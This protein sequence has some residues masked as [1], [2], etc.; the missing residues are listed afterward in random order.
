M[1]NQTPL[2][3]LITLCLLLSVIHWLPAQPTTARVPSP[4]RELR[5][6]WV[7]TVLNIDYPREGTP[8]A[9]AIREQY[10]NLIDQFQQLGFNTVIFQVRPAADAFYP[11]Q[12]VPWSRFLT[13]QQGR[14]PSDPQFDPLA[15]MIEETHRRGMEFHAWLNP[16]RATTDLDSTKLARNHVFFQHRDWLMRY[17]TRYYLNPGIPAVRQHLVDVVSEIVRNYDVDGIHF[18]DYFYPYPLS[19]QRL[20]D[21]L[22][23]VQNRG[24]FTDTLAWRRNNVDQL[25]QSLDQAI[26]GIRPAVAFGISPFGVWRNR[27]RDPR[28]SQTRAGV[29][30]YDDLYAD[31][32][33]W[34]ENDWIDYIM[35][36]LYWNIGFAPADYALLLQ[37]WSRNKSNA[38]LYIGHGAY[39]VGANPEL[40]WNDPA[41]VPRQIDLNRRNYQTQGSAYFSAKSILANPLGLKDSLRRIYATEALWP[42]RDVPNI[43]P[44]PFPEMLKPRN[45]RRENAVML[46]WRVPKG[47]IPTLAAYYA[48]YRY[49]GPQAGS[50]QEPRNLLHITPIAQGCE[51]YYYFDYSAEPGETY[52]YVIT[53]LN[54]AHQESTPSLSRTIRVKRRA[55]VAGATY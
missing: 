18:D 13:G 4:K 20:P 52:T 45:D 23:F 34:M 29:Q 15:F 54:R 10:K 51:Q 48:I 17:G 42:E 14:A 26:H 40:A 46:R 33:K 9:V 41:E 55:R 49:E 12:L 3:K 6:V 38:H 37:W 8:D 44:A 30:T 5:A 36:Q 19:G 24:S 7:A 43:L 22:T 1:L 39:K 50:I 2:P 32:L 31:V 28:G 35:P 16:Y 27:D 47:Q 53:A 11:S 25:I 21:S